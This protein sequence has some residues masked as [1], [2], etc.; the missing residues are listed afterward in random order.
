MGKV[1]YGIIGIGKMGHTHAQ[2]IKKGLDKNATLTAVCD[3]SEERIKWAKQNLQGVKV[4]EDYKELIAMPDVD[5]VVVATPHYLHPEIATHALNSG[6]HTLSEKPAGVYTKALAPLYKAAADH[7]ELTFGIMYN[8]RTNPLYKRAK[9]LIETGALGKLKRINWIITDW[10]RTQAYYDQ[11]G[12]RGTWAGEGGG[13]LLNQSP[14]QLDLFQ[15]LAGMPTKVRG[16]A[17]VGVGRKINV[18]NDVTIYTEYA[19]GASGVFITS[20][21]D[22]PGTNRLEITGDGG[23][24]VIEST[25]LGAKMIFN[26]LNKFESKFNAENKKFMPMRPIKITT[27]EYSTNILQ[28]AIRWGIIGEHM[29]IF[30]NFSKAVL[31]KESLIA[32]GIEGINGLTLSNAA[33]LSTWLNKDIILPIDEDLFYTELQKRVEEEALITAGMTKNE[34]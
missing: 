5:A 9:D 16:Y 11:G 12:W 8:Q 17:K 31:G 23:K 29:Y 4:V 13:V 20:T 25:L 1:R 22:Y 27:Y 18:E 34:H 19:N 14:H 2:K 32:P 21:H 26:K 28:K 3:I 24:I 10:Y 6:K 7:P 15:W 30:R 33:Y